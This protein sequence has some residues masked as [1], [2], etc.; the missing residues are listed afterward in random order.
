MFV[1][2]NGKSKKEGRQA[3]DNPCGLA[4]TD[5]DFCGYVRDTDFS[6]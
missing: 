2:V 5:R 1:Y 6:V 3:G 4:N